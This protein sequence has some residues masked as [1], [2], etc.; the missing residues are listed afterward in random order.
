MSFQS[1]VQRDQGAGNPGNIALIDSGQR[2]QPGILRSTDAANNV[3]GR[4]FRNL[5]TEDLAVS[6]DVP[7]VT[8][9]I[10]AG[11]L[12]NTHEYSSYGNTTDGPLGPTTTL[13]NEVAVDLVTKTAGIYVLLGTGSN[14]AIG[15]VAAF[16]PVDGQI[17]S[18]ADSGSVPG[19]QVEIPRSKI[20][21]NNVGVPGLAILELN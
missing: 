1:T 18:Y 17:Y 12:S 14:G 9:S 21:R 10:F 11:I 2:G 7:A 5:P 19:A 3:I 4:A 13:A 6:A 16:D 8:S 15:D 20:V